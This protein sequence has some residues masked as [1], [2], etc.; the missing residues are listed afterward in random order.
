[1]S[2]AIDLIV[3]TVEALSRERGGDEKMWGSMVKQAI[4]RVRPG[5]NESYYGFKS[6]GAL[7]EAARDAGAITL[8]R[9]EHSGN[10]AVRLANTEE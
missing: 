4:K 3:T 10:Y 2:E 5:F 8:T 9:D 7:L 6:F 1:M